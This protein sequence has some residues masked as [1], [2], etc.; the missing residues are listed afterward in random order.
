VGGSVSF[1]APWGLGL[2]ILTLPIVAAYFFRKKQKP[3]LVSALFLWKVPQ[4]QAQSGR[5]WARFSRELS[6]LFELL[7][8]LAGAFFVADARCGDAISKTPLVIVIDGSL[9][10]QASSKGLTALDRAKN[11]V[12][13]RCAQDDVL[14]TLVASGR[15]PK[16]LVGPSAAAAFV[17]PALKNFE[18]NEPG[19]DLL[20]AMEFAREL[21]P[22]AQVLLVTDGTPGHLETWPA[23][24]AIESVGEALPNLALTSALR[25]DLDNVAT[26]TVR[27]TNWSAEVKNV[28]VLFSDATVGSAS[29]PFRLSV[30]LNPQ[31][32]KNVSAT[33]FAAPLIEVSLADVDDT[34]F[35]NQVLL[36]RNPA[37]T[38]Q[39]R[40]LSDLSAA[41]QTAVR[42]GLSST[43]EVSIEEP[44]NV[45]FGGEAGNA[46]V[47]VGATGKTKMHWGPFFAQRGNE[48]FEDVQLAGVAWAA[49]ENPKGVPLLTSGETVLV[50]EEA[51]GALHLNLDF[52]QSNIARTVAWPVLVANI[53][54]RTRSHLPGFT[55]NQAALGESLSFATGKAGVWRLV[56]PAGESTALSNEGVSEFLSPS[57]GVWTL[58]VDGRM[59]DSISVLSLDALESN[60]MTRGPFR[61]ASELL[62]SQSRAPEPNQRLRWPLWLL[63]LSLAALMMVVTPNRF[64]APSNTFEKGA[65]AP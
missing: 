30:E 1:Q 3:L 65:G 22:D 60:L 45:V 32:T 4:Q 52:A 46:D 59:V 42:R 19:H 14:V 27:V 26:V 10:M 24:A 55:R 23:W 13:Q 2:L 18:A 53:I 40:L 6:L 9:S 34:A 56:S 17:E 33:V 37:K 35:D 12:R 31:E 43:S 44:P 29:Q 38:V 36:T 57:P 8:V 63:L 7:A 61:Q 21:V 41:A 25:R 64:A 48:L 47:T 28:S 15:K 62:A 50:A 11:L 51:S 20:L 16:L 39:V 58:T 54:Q 5:K 49:G